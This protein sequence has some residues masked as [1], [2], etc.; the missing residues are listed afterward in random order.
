MRAGQR[1]SGASS[2]A[3]HERERSYRVR[4]G[5]CGGASGD[6]PQIL[7]RFDLSRVKPTARNRWS[8]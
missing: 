1:E 5:L 8:H 4:Q 6:S 7:N 2:N 3:R